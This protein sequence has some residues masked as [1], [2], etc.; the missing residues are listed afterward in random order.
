[1]TLVAVHRLL[2]VEASL[3]SE[4]GLWSTGSVVVAHGLRCSETCGI[5]QDQGSNLCLLHWQADSLPLSYQGRTRTSLLTLKLPDCAVSSSCISLGLSFLF[6]NVAITTVP[7][8]GKFPGCPELRTPV[9][10]LPWL[11]FNP[12]L[13]NEDS[14]SWVVWPKNKTKESQSLLSRLV[15]KARDNL[16]KE[17]QAEVGT[18]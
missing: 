8:W 9:F 11:G 3:V 13:G 6:C 18:Q 14:A 12:W 10:S 16:C 4:R 5:F 7:T 15:L 17:L 2:I 1:M